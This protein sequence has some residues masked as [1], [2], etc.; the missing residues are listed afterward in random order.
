[1]HFAHGLLLVKHLGMI[2]RDC[3]WRIMGQ[4]DG[5]AL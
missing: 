5:G 4:Y 2:G 1:M 3:N